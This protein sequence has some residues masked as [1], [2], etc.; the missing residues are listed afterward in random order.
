[1]S[2]FNYLMS[3]NMLSGR[4]NCDLNQYFILPWIMASYTSAKFKR[5]D[6]KYRDL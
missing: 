2:N 4:S 3:L 1:M 6:S 5:D